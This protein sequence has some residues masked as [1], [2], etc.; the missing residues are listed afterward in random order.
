MGPVASAGRVARFDG[1]AEPVAVSGA[2]NN[3]LPPSEEYS[4]VYSDI[5]GVHTA[6]LQKKN[7]VQRALTDTAKHWYKSRVEYG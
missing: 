6:Q 4:E 3:S 5:P 2:G 1:V 7:D